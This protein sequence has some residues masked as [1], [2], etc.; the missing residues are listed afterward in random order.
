MVSAKPFKGQKY[1]KIKKECIKKKTLFRDSEF[2][3][4]GLSLFYSKSPPG[5][6]VWKRP[7][8][9]VSNPRFFTEGPGADDFSQGSLGNCWFVAAC[10]CIAERKNL[11]RKVVPDLERQDWGKGRKYAGIFHFQFWQCG[12]WVDV[13]IDDFL[14]TRQG[15]LIYMHS[16]SRNEFW[17]ALLEKAYAKLFGGYE[18][19][20]AG[21]AKDAMVDMTGG[22]AEGI[23]IKDYTTEEEKR[24][25]FKILRKSKEAM[26]L[27]STSIAATGKEME[28]KLSCGLIKGHAYS[29]TGVRK[30]K[31][32]T[33]LRS[34]FS[35]EKI[36]MIRCR[37][38]WGG[39]DWK[40]A[41]SNGS[42]EW[43]K[44]SDGE[45]KELGLT[46]ADNGEF[47]MSFEDFC[48]YFTSIDICHMINTS[49]ISLSKTWKEDVVEG[50]W[51]RNRCGGCANNRTFLENPQYVFEI[52]GF[53]EE[54]LVSLEQ[55]DR[56][57]EKD[58][59]K[60]NYTIGTTI[61]KADLNRK[62]RMHD[63]LERVHS[64]PFSNSRNV[65]A[66]VVLRPGRYVIIP[67]TF[68]PGLHGKY[69]LRIY[70]SKHLNIRELWLD[71]PAPPTICGI[72]STLKK[73][74]TCATQVTMVKGE[75]F[76]G[77]G[78]VGRFMYC[79]ITCDGKVY[80]TRLCK[81]TLNPEWNDRVTFYRSTPKKD[82]HIEVWRRCRL[83]D[84]LL[85]ECVIPMSESAT[86][87]GGNVNRRFGLTARGS[88]N[89]KK[90]GYIWLKILHSNEM[91]RV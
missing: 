60:S 23:E 34:I 85:G 44:V 63:K 49:L 77:N 17:S 72:H 52:R 10:A 74:K 27:I 67:S 14:P 82:I 56:R 36:Y 24:K 43:K 39:S 18:A 62:Y 38:P 33:G 89:V 41:W 90:E 5:D 71:E 55:F 69:I 8:D 20:V 91:D 28:E 87:R 73:K 81:D 86:Y 3:P 54:I 53:E 58:K 12:E 47:W 65:F 35:R 84:K 57:T 4:E 45:K 75:G 83:Q 7:G 42:A 59:G 22:V 66:R 30:L 31:L 46:F 50:E 68:E 21:K 70:S 51:K 13:V 76:P 29:V 37:N 19:L 6:V 78:N 26:S 2:P 40:G 61:V 32:G 25:L 80:K 16:K 88:K 48:R 11:L 79:K 1:H 9:I 15:R 64:G